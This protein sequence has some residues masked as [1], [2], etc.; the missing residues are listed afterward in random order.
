MDEEKRKKYICI[1]IP[2]VKTCIE[3]YILYIYKYVVKIIIHKYIV[4]INIYW[5]YIFP[6]FIHPLIFLF[7]HIFFP[8]VSFLKNLF[9][10]KIIFFLSLCCWNGFF[11]EIVFAPVG[12]YIYFSWSS[13]VLFPITCSK[14]LE[15][16]GE[17]DDRGWDGWMA[18]LTRWTWVW[19]NSGSW[20]WTGRPGVLRFMGSKRVG[21]NWR[22]ELNWTELFKE[23]QI[24]NKNKVI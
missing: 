1:H 5:K 15:A 12:R 8:T 2:I 22:T 19:V 24:L 4:K 20:W 23:M 7:I 10:S 17:G 9:F 11:Q 18:S 21:H 13:L 16:G 14:R 6:F 3:I